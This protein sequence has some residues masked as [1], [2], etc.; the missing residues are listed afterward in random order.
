MENNLSFE[1]E[2]YNLLVR[3]ISET[4]GLSL[5]DTLDLSHRSM[6]AQERP[7]VREALKD[8]RTKLFNYHRDA[9]NIEPLLNHPVAGALGTFL[10]NFPSTYC[11]EH[12]HLTG[13][14]SA[15][16][17]YPRLMRLLDGPNREAYE[18]KI[19]SIY[20][21]GVLPIETEADVDK[22]IRMEETVSFQHYLQVLTLG[23]LVLTDSEA[24]R[25]AAYHMASTLYH[26][27]NVGRV[28]L[29]FSLSRATTN[30]LDALP[31]DS[32]SPEDVVLGLY[33]GFE[34]FRREVPA[35]D[36]VLAPSF[37]KESDFYDA[38]RFSSKQLDFENQVKLILQLIENHPYLRERIQ[39]VDTVGDER[40]HY[41]KAHFEVMRIGMRKLQFQGIQVRSH[42]GE[43]WQTLQ[44]G[45]Q[46]VDNA[47]N[48]WHVN[49]IEHGISLG[50][51]P[52]Y[53]FHNIFEKAM[54]QNMAGE[55]LTPGSREQRE[56]GAMD[57]Q[58]H[59]E[60]LTKLISGQL[61]NQKEIQRFIKIKFHTARE[62]EHY[63]H[64]VL[65]RMIDKNVTLV[66]LPSSNIKLTETFPSYQDHPFSWWEKKGLELA[67]GTDNYVTLNT[68]LIREMLILL[69]SD[70]EELKILKLLMTATGE[71]RRP[72]LSGQLWD[73]RKQLAV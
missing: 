43:T 19:R 44:H 65:N 17:I 11:E 36:Y 52:N 47:M 39:D 61:L 2:L 46:A 62:L 37:R 5:G 7:P 71:T 12:I 3:I 55:S 63:Q 27:F 22:L 13:S 59:P 57:F 9:V 54:E 26:Q 24:H 40:E 68:N 38:D 10:G 49:A 45:V 53:Y 33:D 31:G 28:H 16:F 23:K 58:K 20:G 35:F 41:R 18:A 60:L 51:N 32:V 29:K 69:C 50:V 4:N 70:V 8:F 72:V 34:S 48:L 73:M 67:I 25:D 21:E 56:V 1:L 66:A 64:D 30:P 42:H 14:L 15:D 6:M